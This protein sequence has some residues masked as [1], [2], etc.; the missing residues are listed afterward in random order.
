MH[1][2]RVKQLLQANKHKALVKRY[3]AFYPYL[4]T[5]NYFRRQHTI[6]PIRED[7]MA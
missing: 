7:P 5:S 4:K 3:I 2:F 6:F 1:R